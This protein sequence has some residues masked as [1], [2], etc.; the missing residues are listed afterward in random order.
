MTTFIQDLRQAKE[1]FKIQSYKKKALSQILEY[2]KEEKKKVNNKTVYNSQLRDLI[3][4]R[5][6]IE[7]EDL[8]EYLATEVF[9]AQHDLV[10]E[11][12]EEYKKQM[13]AQGYKQLTEKIEYRGKIELIAQK[14]TDYLTRPISINATIKE[15][16]NGRLFIIP[17]GNRTRGYYVSSLENA[18]YKELN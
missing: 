12:L 4:K 6:N 15:L 8:I 7:N 17:K 5:E 14:T 16:P 11:E 9:L 1:E 18:F 2:L 10:N 13:E 3:I